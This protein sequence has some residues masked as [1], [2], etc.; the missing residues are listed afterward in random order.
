MCRVSERVW[1]ALN[2]G[3]RYP[4][5]RCVQAA[6]GRSGYMVTAVTTRV[7]GYE[8]RLCVCACSSRLCLTCV[9]AALC[10]WVRLCVCVCVCV[11]VRACMLVC[12]CLCVCMRVCI[13]MS[14]RARVHA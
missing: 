10:Q 2:T 6:T 11:Y 13:C 1:Q 4:V 3:K 14:V 5:L 12:V 8:L 7:K 9:C